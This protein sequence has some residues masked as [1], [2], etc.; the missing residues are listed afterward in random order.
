MTNRILTKFLINFLFLGFIYSVDN[1]ENWLEYNK[2]KIFS[3]SS[4]SKVSFNLKFNTFA[5][6]EGQ[7]SDSCYVLLD[8]S[9]NIFQI[10]LFD[11]I[12]YHN[13][14]R[15]DQ[16]NILSNQ[17]FRYDEDILVTGL[18]DMIISKDNFFNF[19]KYNYQPKSDSYIFT[20]NNLNL[21]FSM[22][23]NN[24]NIDYQDSRYAINVSN[25]KITEMTKIDF[26]NLLLYNMIDTN[27]I[28]IFN[29]K[30]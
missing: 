11:N 10:K 3:E 24:I 23:N 26:K 14:S 21:K 12:I 8:V 20:L 27:S 1:F 22:I 9:N 16:Y 2:N 29:F 5:D 30:N 19:S 7:Q 13:K 18:I 28:Q 4:L 17:F 15:T 25:L 6:F